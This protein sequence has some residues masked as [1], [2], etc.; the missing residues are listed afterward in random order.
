M[1]RYAKITLLRGKT[2]NK[3]KELRT[4]QGLSLAKLS[5]QLQDNY[6]LKISA[7]SLMRYENGQTEPKLATWQKLADFFEVPVSY[8]QGLNDWESP[9]NP[10][11]RFNN[12]FLTFQNK[13][14]DTGTSAIEFQN[15]KNRLTNLENTLESIESRKEKISREE[16]TDLFEQKK[17]IVEEG[18]RLIQKRVKELEEIQQLALDSAKYLNAE[19]E[20]I[21]RIEELFNDK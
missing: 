4:Q 1:K 18:R 21:K 6:D 16:L 15:Y 12:A 8:L 2:M 14:T 7:P 13:Y 5:E 10:E 20:E 17:I 9:N 3:I 11:N 19:E